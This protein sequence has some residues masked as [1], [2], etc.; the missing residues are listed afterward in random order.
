MKKILVLLLVL[1]IATSI[2][3]ISAFATGTPDSVA[4]QYIDPEGYYHIYIIYD[5]YKVPQ[6]TILSYG[7]TGQY[8]NTAQM[9]LNEVALQSSVGCSV[10]A[11][12]GDFG[13][14]TRNGVYAF[15][16]WFNSNCI[17]YGE[18][19]IDVDGIIGNQTWNAFSKLMYN[20]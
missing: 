13:N 9:K 8:V 20:Y 12:D 1:V 4:P 14:N 15:Q 3:P 11:V 6:G 19:A 18:G 5:L 7:S 2:F 10:G 17:Y 16:R